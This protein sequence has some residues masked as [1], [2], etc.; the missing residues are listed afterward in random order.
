MKV[1]NLFHIKILTKDQVKEKPRL[2]RAG[3][4]IAEIHDNPRLASETSGAKR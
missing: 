3:G 2:G 4:V 1:Y